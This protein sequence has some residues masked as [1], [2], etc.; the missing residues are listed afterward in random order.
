MMIITNSA[1]IRDRTPPVSQCG[2]GLILAW[3]HMCLWVEFV[4]GFH[5][6][7]VVPPQNQ[8]LQIQI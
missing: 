6:A 4:V 5:L 2:P 8:Q 7:P 1:M 3:C